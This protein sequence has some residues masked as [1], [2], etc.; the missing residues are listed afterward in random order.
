MR[1]FNESLLP[2]A[3]IEADG[4]AAYYEV[5]FR[6][7]EVQLQELH[8][9]RVARKEAALQETAEATTTP[10]L[11]IIDDDGDS[12]AILALETKSL[13]EAQKGIIHIVDGDGDGTLDEILPTP[14]VPKQ[15]AAA[16]SADAVQD[17]IAQLRE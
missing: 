5:M 4:V 7:W 16:E 15:P 17:R 13:I 11:V 10:E 6:H 12:D 1:Y 8:A 9:Q 2:T 3:S 14:E